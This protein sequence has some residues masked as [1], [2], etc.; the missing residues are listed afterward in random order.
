MNIGKKGI[1]NK[2]EYHRPIWPADVWPAINIPFCSIFT[3]FQY[4][5]IH[6]LALLGPDHV[7]LTLVLNWDAELGHSIKN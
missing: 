5:L 1:F 6:D 4:L 2:R 7:Q 3:Y